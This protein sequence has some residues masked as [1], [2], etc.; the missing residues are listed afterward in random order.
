MITFTLD[1]IL[2]RDD[3]D[4]IR[5]N[6]PTFTEFTLTHES[7]YFEGMPWKLL[8]RY[9]ARNTHLISIDFTELY[10][11][12]ESLSYFFS[13]MP[14]PKVINLQ[15]NSAKREELHR[16]QGIPYRYDSIFAE[17]DPLVLPDVLALVASE[18]GQTELFRML[19]NSV[20]DLF[21]T[22]N[23]KMVVKQKLDDKTAEM[24]DLS[25]KM[26]ALSAKMVDLS[27]EISELREELE[28]C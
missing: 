18:H 9:I 12:K 25:A 1:Q 17:I 7:N 28:H 8:G 21:S 2:H 13:E 20:S 22:V 4:K 26:A 14:R 19:V 27:A 11:G 24:E 23:R 6:D 15:L 3:V 16:L 10:A 5:R